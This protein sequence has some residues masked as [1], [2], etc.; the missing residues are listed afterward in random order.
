VDEI[1]AAVIETIFAW[2]DKPEIGAEAS[3]ASYRA[4]GDGRP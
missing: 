2:R 4:R 3:E 1:G